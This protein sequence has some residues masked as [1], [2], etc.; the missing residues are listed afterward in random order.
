MLERST[1]QRIGD[2]EQMVTSFRRHLLAEND[3]SQTTA[4]YTTRPPTRC[5]PG[6]ARARGRGR[7]DSQPRIDVALVPFAVLAAPSSTCSTSMAA[8]PQAIQLRR[9]STCRGEA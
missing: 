7:R 5:V 6:R 2:V 9:R 1:V 4:A 8:S 3:A